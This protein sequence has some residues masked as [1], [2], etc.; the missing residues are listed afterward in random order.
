VGDPEWVGLLERPDR[1]HGPNNRFVSRW[2]Y[3]LVPEG[4]TLDL[5]NIHNQAEGSVALGQVNK[6]YR[7]NM[8]VGTWE[9]NLAAFLVDLN[10]NTW[11]NYQYEPFF[12]TV[13]GVS[14]ND[15]ESLLAYRYQGVNA[16][17][18]P[19]P[20]QW[21]LFGVFPKAGGILDVDLVDSFGAGPLMLG[22]DLPIN[23]LDATRNNYRWPGADTPN[24][25][26]SNQDLF[27]RTKTS[28][29]VTPG[30][31]T[32][33][34]RLIRSGTQSPSSYDRYT[35]YRL[36]SQLGTDSGPEPAKMHLNY[37][38]VVAGRVVPNG[39]TNFLAWQP[40]DFFTNAAVRLLRAHGRGDALTNGLLNIPV[41]TNGVFAYSSSLNRI[42]QLAANIHDS[43]F[44]SSTNGLQFP[45]IY[46]PIF[47]KDGLDVYI[48]DFALV[49]E[50]WPVFSANHT[51]RDLSSPTVVAALQP[52]DL[53][54]GVPLIV[55]ARKGLPNFNKFVVQ[56]SSEIV[57]KLQ[58][59][60][61]STR[62]PVDLV[63]TNQAYF[64]GITNTIAAQAWNSYAQRGFTNV[65]I[66][67]T[68][69]SFASFRY[70]ND[71]QLD[72]RFNSTNVIVVS[73]AA[74]NIVQ[75]P[76]RGNS[77][78]TA[79]P[80]SFQIPILTNI[81]VQPDAVLRSRLAA[82][83]FFDQDLN[84]TGQQNNTTQLKWHQ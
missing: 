3:T 30:N 22:T 20:R 7:R 53:V 63:A 72:A 55:A 2:A 14:F 48:S 81:L 79:N 8:G 80:E 49:T 24:R 26:I 6:G 15:A 78:R 13:Q 46:R 12:P 34:D 82:Q 11:G 47:R 35:Y 27:D 40:L 43:T 83:P 51:L 18:F 42:L 62:R 25:F 75:W 71:Y 70:T 59:E 44:D 4:L 28:F 37:K 38:N 68:N 50:T 69:V 31:L 73:G 19:A 33:T 84:F 17:N 5:N 74:T 36:L 76:S 65:V 32:F 77:S 29:G 61:R 52:N 9:L 41:Y 67:A 66:I 64:V 54:F 57:R 58:I 23:D 60:R 45:S 21:S 16:A 39:Q 10:T 56:S 1:P